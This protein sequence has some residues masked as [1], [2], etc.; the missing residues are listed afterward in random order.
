MEKTEKHGKIYCLRSYQ[1]DRIYIGSTTEKYL[2]NRL[3]GHKSD[4]KR[5]L[6][7]KRKYLSSFE[8]M[9]L[10]DVYVELLHDCG[11]ITNLEL[12]KIE[13]N[14][15]RNNKT[16]CVNI[17]IETRTQNEYKQDNKEH[18]RELQKEYYE[19]NKEHLSEL[20]KKWYENN[21]DQIVKKV[22]EYRKGNDNYHNKQK[23]Y[24]DGN[25]QKLKTKRKEHYESKKHILL[26][27]HE[28]DVCG[29]RYV[30]QQK[31]RHQKTKKHIVALNNNLHT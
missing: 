22:M 16:I 10:D 27:S 31:L 13:G 23:K 19:N 1:T 7:G 5:Y 8:L 6:N 28:C 20:Q 4:Y 12:R 24:R 3:C 2:S 15:I 17:R 25:K 11:M 29:G 18:L 26:E 30:S 14:H 9:K 21:K